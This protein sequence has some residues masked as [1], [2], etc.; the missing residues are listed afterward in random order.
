MMNIIGYFIIE[1]LNHIYILVSTE[2]FQQVNG[3]KKNGLKKP[4]C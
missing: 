4:F 2:H 1:I 3:L